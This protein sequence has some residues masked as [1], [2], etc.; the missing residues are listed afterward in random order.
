MLTSRSSAKSEPSGNA[1]SP[2]SPHSAKVALA[3]GSQAYAH[4]PA[5]SQASCAVTRVKRVR[6]TTVATF[7]LPLEDSPSHMSACSFAVHIVSPSGE[8]VSDSS[9]RFERSL[10]RWIAGTGAVLPVAVPS[11]PNSEMDG[12]VHS[13]LAHKVPESGSSASPSASRRPAG[14]NAA[15]R[16][17]DSI[18]PVEESIPSARG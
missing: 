4:S 6:R 12:G 8:I 15:P 1:Q 9:D 10:S 18:A 5:A 16:V 13:E 2:D 11:V 3:Q 7:V 17:C 14:V